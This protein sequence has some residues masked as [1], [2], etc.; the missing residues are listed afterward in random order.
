MQKI[1]Y[2]DA[3]K[4]YEIEDEFGGVYMDLKEIK[5]LLNLIKKTYPNVIEEVMK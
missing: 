2:D 3:R 4:C 1:S 5:R